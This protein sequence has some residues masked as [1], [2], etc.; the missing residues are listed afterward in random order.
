MQELQELTV[1]FFVS[2]FQ[3]L[4]IWGILLAV[5]FGAIW[6]ACF[7]PPLIKNPWHWAVMVSSALITLL[8][9]SFIQRP[10][11]NIIGNAMLQTW[12][13]EA[14]MNSL[15]L[16]GMPTYLL[17]GLIQEGAKMVPVGIYWWRKG[18]NIDCRLAL[19]LGAAAGVGFGILEA[20]WI[21]N[22]TLSMGWSWEL[23]KMRGLEALTPFTERFFVVAFSTAASALIGYGLAK[24]QG[25]QFYIIISLVHTALNYSIFL[26]QAK[27]FSFVQAE[28]FIALLSLLIMGIALWLR[29][30]KTTNLPSNPP[31]KS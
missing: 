14:L 2:F 12:G 24:G 4:N 7:W 17:T 19:T 8:A 26:V 28:V 18:K 15:L 23:T 21:H 11:Q 1:G 16:S 3:N 20:Q 22:M 9:I 31:T 5:M 25:W 13:S 10:L 29:W 30:R 6:L 27:I